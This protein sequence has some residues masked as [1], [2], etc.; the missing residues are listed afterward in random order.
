MVILTGAAFQCDT[1]LIAPEG[2]AG[3]AFCI[4]NKEWFT[5]ILNGL[6]QNPEVKS[7]VISYTYHGQTVFY[8]DSCKGCADSMA[9]VYTCSGEIICQFGGIAGFNTCP[10]FA[11][12]AT[13]KKVIWQK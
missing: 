2:E 13:H 7:E 1:T 3:A 10:D 5:S 11:D 9:L 6:K 12:F 4:K 8:I